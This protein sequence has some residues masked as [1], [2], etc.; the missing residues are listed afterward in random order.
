[1]SVTAQELDLAH[2][3]FYCQVMQDKKNMDQNQQN[4]E[5]H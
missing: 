3:G 5:K 1:M 4:P 2:L